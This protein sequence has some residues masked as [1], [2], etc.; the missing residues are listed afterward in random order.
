MSAPIGHDHSGPDFACEACKPLADVLRSRM[1][2]RSVHWGVLHDDAYSSLA[3]A[4]FE[5]GR[6]VDRLAIPE[7]R[8]YELAQTDSGWTTRLVK[9]GRTILSSG[10]QCYS[11]RAGAERAADIADPERRF[12]RVVVD[13]RTKP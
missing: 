9:N 10:S 7:D 3:R 6:F 12:E 13:E 1:A 2:W 5:S 8:H 11:R 4:V